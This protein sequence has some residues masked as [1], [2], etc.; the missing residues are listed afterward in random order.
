MNNLRIEQTLTSLLL[1]IR[2]S[3]QFIFQF[4]DGIIVVVNIYPLLGRKPFIIDAW[5]AQADI[6][7]TLGNFYL[8]YLSAIINQ[9]CIQIKLMSFQHVFSE[10]CAESV[11]I[12]Q[13]V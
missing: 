4:F 5:R 13:W 1:H 10:Q 6:F 11:C 3:D 7:F 12:T 8:I 9:N 2:S